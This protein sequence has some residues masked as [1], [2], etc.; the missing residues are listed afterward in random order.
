MNT[1]TQEQEPVSGVDL[2]RFERQRQ[3]NKEGWT[4]EHDAQHTDRSLA[5][6]AACYATHSHGVGFNSVPVVWPWECES[7]K[8]SDDPIRNLVKAGALIAAE[9]DRL[10]AAKK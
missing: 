5:Y 6:A 9:I 10:Q 8:P 2:I 4:P 3:I 1:Q 7:W